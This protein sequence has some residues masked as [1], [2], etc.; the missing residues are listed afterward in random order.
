MAD[1]AR[2]ATAADDA[3]HEQVVRAEANVTLLLNHHAYAVEMDDERIAAVLA[4]DTRTNAR[5]RIAGRFFADCTGHGTIGVLAGADYEMAGAEDIVMGMTNKWD[6]EMTG[7]L[8]PFPLTP[9]ALDLEWATSRAYNR[10]WRME[11][12]KRLLSQPDTQDLEYIRDLESSV[13]C[14]AHGMPEESR[15]EQRITPMRG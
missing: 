13:P 11:L 9:W 2:M 3:H 6:W 5:K 14:L 8:Q 12:G 7:T 15:A 10:P 1:D 4:L